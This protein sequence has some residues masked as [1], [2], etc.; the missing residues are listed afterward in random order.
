MSVS[1]SKRGSGA[2]ATVTVSSGTIKKVRSSWRIRV[3]TSVD[4]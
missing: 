3:E 2:I 4:G 1:C